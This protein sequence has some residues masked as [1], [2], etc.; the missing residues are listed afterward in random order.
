MFILSGIAK[1]LQISGISG[2][3]L[4]ISGMYISECGLADINRAKGL[5]GLIDRKR[6]PSVVSLQCEFSNVAS[7][8]L[9]VQKHTHIGCIC[10]FFLQSEFSNGSL[11]H[12]LE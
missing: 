4:Q 6:M 2:I 12:L 10:T 3:N 5:V 8:C 9:P 7:N 11:N 1:N